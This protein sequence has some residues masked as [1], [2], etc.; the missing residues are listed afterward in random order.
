M[1]KIRYVYVVQEDD[2]GHITTSYHS[3]L[4]KAKEAYLKQG[5]KF[6]SRVCSDEGIISYTWSSNYTSCLTISKEV[7]E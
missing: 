5:G 3:S 4:K 6:T 7:L 1:S 2:K